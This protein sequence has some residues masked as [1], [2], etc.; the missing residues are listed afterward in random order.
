[1]LT[2]QE[3]LNVLNRINQSFLDSLLGL[4]TQDPSLKVAQITLLELR[5]EEESYALFVSGVRVADIRDLLVLVADRVAIAK[6]GPS[7]EALKLEQIASTQVGDL[8]IIE[9]IDDFNAEPLEWFFRDEGKK[10]KLKVGTYQKCSMIEGRALLKD[11]KT[12]EHFVL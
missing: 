12:G 5:K 9:P 3:V 6:A 7:L 8:V 11:T 4:S 1:M 2:F 10:D